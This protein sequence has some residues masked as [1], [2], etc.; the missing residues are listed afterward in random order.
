M[1]TCMCL[2]CKVVHGGQIALRWPGVCERDIIRFSRRTSHQQQCIYTLCVVFLGDLCS[3]QTTY[4]PYPWWTKAWHVDG[5]H[6]SYSPLSFSAPPSALLTSS[7]SVIDF[8]SLPHVCVRVYACV[9][10]CVR[11]CMYVSV[12]KHVYGMCVCGCAGFHSKNNGIPE[13]HIRNFTC[14]VGV[15]QRERR[16]TFATSHV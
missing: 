2:C 10:A 3:N 1:R 7:H 8:P 14:L 6:L 9:S 11:A 15:S 16:D 5:V 13:G 4:T 12:C